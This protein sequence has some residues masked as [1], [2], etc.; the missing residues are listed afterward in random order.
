MA[1]YKQILLKEMVEQLGEENV[2][3]ILSNFSCPNNLD[4]ENFIKYKA[5][6]FSKQNIAPTHLIFAD[7]KSNLE[8]V[9]YFTLTPKTIF[10]KKGSLNSKL[11]KRIS[12]FGTYDD[13]LKG[14][15]ITAP[16]IAQLGKN[17]TN[18][19]NNLITGDEL[20]KMAC[21]KIKAIQINIGGKV[22]YIECEDKPKL[23]EFYGDN[24]FVNFGRRYLDNDEKDEL[25]GNY[26]VQM[27]KYLE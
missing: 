3:K 5:I 17:F 19:L 1:G 26:L 2:K 20:L 11:S 9:G 18:G 24:G 27:L 15:N 25:S 12:K 14:Y 22:T 7:Y 21:D 4:V 13:N 6:E 8:L 10:I 16:L 23:L